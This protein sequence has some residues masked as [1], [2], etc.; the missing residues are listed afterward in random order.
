MSITGN[1]GW[2]DPPSVW[3][4][5]DAA[6]AWRLKQSYGDE[7]TYISGGTWLSAQWENGAAKPKHLI[8]LSC[9]SG[10][11]GI[12][13]SSKETTIGAL[14]ALTTLR[15]DPFLS[16]HY[17][18]IVDAVTGIAAPSIRN[19]ATIG[20]NI[21]CR[22]G[23]ILPALMISEAEL[24]WHDGRSVQREPLIQWLERVSE[25]TSPQG[26]ILT[27]VK[28]QLPE[29]NP[30]VR[31]LEVYQKIGRREAFTPSVVTA[32]Y[33]SDIDTISGEIGRIR[34]AVGGGQT[35]PHRLH[36]AEKLLLN[37]VMSPELMEKLYEQVVLEAQLIG[38]AF[39][40]AAYRKRTAAGLISALLWQQWQ[41]AG[42]M[43]GR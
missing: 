19:A 23:D 3:H 26:R 4:P 21:A 12:T 1:E 22:T 37:A 25:G 6:E 32:A 40:S 17:R 18:S 42:K 20:G 11:K 5:I 36:G 15:R 27:Q 39:V 35:V 29:A 7:A 28:L 8:D 41:N 30:L 31:R 34:I 10:M 38:D 16:E 24:L 33:T 2:Q 14:T 9:I 43:G 13:F